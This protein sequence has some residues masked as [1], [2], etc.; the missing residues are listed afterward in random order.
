MV[1]VNST[2][3]IAATG[4]ACGNTLISA[5]VTTNK[6]SGN[7]VT[8]YM[9]VTVVCFTGTGGGGTTGP[10]LTLSVGGGTGFVTSTPPGISCASNCFFSFSNGTVVMLTANPV[11]PSTTANWTSACDTVTGNVCTVTM[12]GNRAVA[13][14]FN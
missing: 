12:N 4:N 3:L 8:G 10:I 6:S 11:A 14:T 9:T 1:T 5:T 2:G 7:I 13:V